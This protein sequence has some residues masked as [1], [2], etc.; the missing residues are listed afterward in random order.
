MA[1]FTSS[2]FS[3][4]PEPV[5]VAGLVLAGIASFVVAWK[6]SA[7]SAADLV[8]V[9]PAKTTRPAATAAS[10]QDLRDHSGNTAS[11]SSRENSEDPA[12]ARLQS[13]VAHDPFGPL[14]RTVTVEQLREIPLTPEQLALANRPK[15]QPK[16]PKPPEPPPVIAEPAPLP[17][18]E[19]VAPPVPFTAVGSIQGKRIADGNT[20]AFLKDAADII[21]IVRV[22]DD[23]D[24]KY[25]V[26]KITDQHI[27]LLYLP[28]GKLQLLP[29][30]R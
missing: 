14:N 30:S 20:L 22:G 28:L 6:L 8:I 15:R 2:K 18:P 27:E 19:P 10:G 1:P 21:R 12:P 17:P 5:K 4:V 13:L 7:P 11:P 23:I 24:G 9:E 26:Q 3:A 29:I 25:K 16:P